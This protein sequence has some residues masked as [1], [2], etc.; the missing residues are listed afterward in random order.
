[1]IYRL[2]QKTFS[3]IYKRCGQISQFLIGGKIKTEKFLTIVGKFQTFLIFT[4]AT[5]TGK[6]K[7]QE[8]GHSTCMPPTMMSGRF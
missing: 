1:M 5:N 7:G 4:T 2:A 3:Q 6:K 8:M